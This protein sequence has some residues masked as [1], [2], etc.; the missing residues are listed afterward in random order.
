ALLLGFWLLIPVRTDAE[1]GGITR[2]VIIIGIV[3]PLILIWMAVGLASAIS[4]LRA[5][6]AELRS[7]LDQLKQLASKPPK[8]TPP[9]VVP[10][11]IP[12]QPLPAAQPRPAAIAQPR[13]SAAAPH[14]ASMD[15]DSPEPAPI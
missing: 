1:T 4:D 15:F 3:M 12:T 9:Q 10:E 6:A 5:E 13:Q 2:L 8:S 7:D 11:P 14:Q